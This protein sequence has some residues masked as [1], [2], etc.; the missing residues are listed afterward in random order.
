MKKNK[1][2]IILNIL[3][4]L[5]I[6]SNNIWCGCNNSSCK[7]NN[8][9]NT[10][11]NTDKGPIQ[12][13]PTQEEIEKNNIID[14]CEKLI[15]EIKNIKPDYSKII[16]KNDTKEN[17]KTLKTQLESDLNSY[18]KIIP[19]KTPD[20][21]SEEG[22]SEKEELILQ[23]TNMIDKLIKNSTE[24]FKKM[25]KY[26]YCNGDI[27]KTDKQL[28]NSMIKIFDLSAKD[29]EEIKNSIIPEFHEYFKEGI[30]VDTFM[31]KKIKNF[32][33]KHIYKNVNSLEHKGTLKK[34][35]HNFRKLFFKKEYQSEKDSEDDRIIIDIYTDNTNL[36]NPLKYYYCYFNEN[37]FEKFSEEINN[38]VNIKDKLYFFCISLKADNKINPLY[39]IYAKENFN[40]KISEDLEL[41]IEMI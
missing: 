28:K 30:F 3:I 15:L 22:K 34:T 14:E 6:C 36:E 24:K 31:S 13:Q 33:F 2:M 29:S 10:Y 19:D 17:L 26:V 1:K 9:S 12:N 32:D 37:I 40:F 8:N 11:D 20:D 23:F 41:T 27:K 7:T 25:L 38:Y 18:I 35:N 16:N 5:F 21:D 39:H 4:L